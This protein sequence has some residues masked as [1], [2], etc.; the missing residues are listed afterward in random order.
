MARWDESLQMQASP[1]GSCDGP[2]PKVLVKDV[3]RELRDLLAVVAA[4]DRRRR[5]ADLDRQ[6]GTSHDCHDPDQ[7]VRGPAMAPVRSGLYY[8]ETKT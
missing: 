6:Q 3:Q 4:R 8:A 5:G 7:H 1:R 2:C